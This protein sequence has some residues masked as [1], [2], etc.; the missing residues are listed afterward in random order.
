[1]KPQTIYKGPREFEIRTG[2]PED[3]GGRI[4]PVSPAAHAKLREAWGVP[5]GG[6]RLIERGRQIHAK[7]KAWGDAGRPAKAKRARKKGGPKI[8][9]STAQLEEAS[10][11]HEAGESLRAIA[12]DFELSVHT[13]HA[14]L[15]EAGHDTSRRPRRER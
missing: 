2:E 7:S 10:R 1:M 8:V 3:Q 9:L 13:L 5:P 12:A 15:R 6:R 11:R 14:R 4:H